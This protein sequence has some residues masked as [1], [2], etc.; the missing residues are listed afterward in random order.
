V[1]PLQT[2][3]R[4]IGFVVLSSPRTPFDID[5]EVLDLLKTAQRQA[6]GY[7]DRMLAAEA[8]SRRASSTPSTACRP[9]WCTT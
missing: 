7:L 8:C 5:W 2:A 9:S 1:I 3:E 6:A 4:L